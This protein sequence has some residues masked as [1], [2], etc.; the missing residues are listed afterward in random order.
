ML[1]EFNMMASYR[2]RVTVV[3]IHPGA[4]CPLINSGDDV[5]VVQIIRDPNT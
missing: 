5:H 3:D 2:V 1:S 4:L